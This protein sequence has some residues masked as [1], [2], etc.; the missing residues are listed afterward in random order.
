MM[1][2]VPLPP[3]TLEAQAYSMFSLPQPLRYFP[4]PLFRIIASRDRDFRTDT[5]SLTMEE[6]VAPD[7]AVF[8]HQVS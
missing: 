1:V 3:V 4:L 7:S 2:S 8:G 6:K 5:R